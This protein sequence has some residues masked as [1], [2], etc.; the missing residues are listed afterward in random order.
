MLSDAFHFCAETEAHRRLGRR[1]RPGAVGGIA[2]APLD[3]VEEATTSPG[4][5]D[6]DP[7]REAADEL[8]PR[9]DVELSVDAA[10]VELHR[11]R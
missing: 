2:D 3:G 4:G 11:L 9:G 7:G 1:G 5:A 6:D 10:Q 8:G